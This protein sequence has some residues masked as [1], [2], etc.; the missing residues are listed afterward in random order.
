MHDARVVLAVAAAAISTRKMKMKSA[1]QSQFSAAN[2]NK[3][4]DFRR[5]KWK[6]KRCRNND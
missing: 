1:M 3:T 5:Q 4:D 6:G 2:V